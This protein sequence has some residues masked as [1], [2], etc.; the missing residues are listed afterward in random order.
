MSSSKWMS[1]D[2]DEDADL[3]SKAP[4]SEFHGGK[5]VD[6]WLAVRWGLS[7]TWPSAM[8]DAGG[9]RRHVAAT[10]PNREDRAEDSSETR[11]QR[12]S[13][14]LPHLGTERSQGALERLPSPDRQ[15][16]SRRKSR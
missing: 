16:S 4:W 6:R 14:H 5:H 1:C 7:G 2:R 9:R 12:R 13:A 8:M 10:N 11:Y 15:Q 3:Q